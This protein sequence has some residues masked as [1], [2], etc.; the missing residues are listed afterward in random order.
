M[1]ESQTQQREESRAHRRKY[2]EERRARI[3]QLFAP[4]RMVRTV[5]FFYLIS[6]GNVVVQSVTHL[7]GEMSF[8]QFLRLTL[9]FYSLCVQKQILKEEH[10]VDTPAQKTAATS[11]SQNDETND[12]TISDIESQDAEVAESMQDRIRMGVDDE[13]EEDKFVL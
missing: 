8:V 4:V 10:F 5:V 9:Y 12:N 11:S 1:T 6:V 13:D 3:V 2:R 7:C